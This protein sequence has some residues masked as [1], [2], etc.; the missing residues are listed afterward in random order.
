VPG[1]DENT[2]FVATPGD[3]ADP[4][5]NSEAVL[6]DEVDEDESTGLVATPGDEANPELNIEAVLGEDSEVEHN[7]NTGLGASPQAD[8]G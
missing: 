5:V 2:G 4:K 6:G 3:E 1:K 7:E 8:G